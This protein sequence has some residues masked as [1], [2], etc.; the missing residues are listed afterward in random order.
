LLAAKGL[1]TR[2]ARK[3]ADAFARS[4]AGTLRYWESSHL[5]RRASHFLESLSHLFSSSESSEV[6]MPQAFSEFLDVN[7]G[8][9]YV[10]PNIFPNLAHSGS[11]TGSHS[12]ASAT[13]QSAICGT[14][15]ETCKLP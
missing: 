10:F 1:S 12:T 11:E 5:F 13:T 3:V 8:N 14:F 15:L 6:P 2:F 9:L 7:L 4:F